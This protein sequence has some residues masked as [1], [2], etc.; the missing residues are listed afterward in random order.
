VTDDSNTLG[1]GIGS[2]LAILLLGGAIFIA[3]RRKKKR[4]RLLIQSTNK[5]TVVSL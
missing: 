4:H 1:I 3:I 2:S 5:P